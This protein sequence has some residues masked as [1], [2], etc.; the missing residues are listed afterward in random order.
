MGNICEIF[1]KNKN[2]NNDEIINPIPCTYIIHNKVDIS[3]NILMYSSLDDQL[4]SY[5]E[6]YSNY[7]K[8]SCNT[9]NMTTEFLGGM[10]RE[11]ILYKDLIYHYK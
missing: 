5:S 8:D 9:T 2:V 10:L 11:D 7:K 1:N 3:D 6:L 4:P